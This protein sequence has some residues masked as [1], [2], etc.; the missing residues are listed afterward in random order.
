MT[1]NAPA[2]L[3]KALGDIP[4]LANDSLWPPMLHKTK[5]SRRGGI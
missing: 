4:W 1:E 2:H 5:K 3:D